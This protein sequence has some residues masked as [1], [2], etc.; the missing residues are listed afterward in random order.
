MWMWI[1]G[2]LNFL[3]YVPMALVIVY[4]GTVV[5]SAWRIR[6]VKGTNYFKTDGR[7]EKRLALK[8][9]V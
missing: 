9:L 6:F 8:M 3:L 4:D 7:S 5:V 1:T 2:F